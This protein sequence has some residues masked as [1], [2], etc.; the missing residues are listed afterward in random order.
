MPN[1][2][3]YNPTKKHSNINKKS[4]HKHNKQC[5]VK[6]NNYK[7]QN[8]TEKYNKSKYNK[9][10][11]NKTKY[12]K[13]KN[14]KTKK[15][16]IKLDDKDYLTKIG[17][18]TKLGKEDRH[19]ILLKAITN[20]GYS[21]VIKRLVE[22]RTLTKNTQPIKSKKYNNDIIGLQK[23]KKY[24]EQMMKGGNKNNKNL[25]KNNLTKIN[26]LIKN[27]LAIEKNKNKNKK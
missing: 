17:Y 5:Y 11:Y 16:N 26:K 15:V 12:N 13:T 18:S 25:S 8:T 19:K 21:S 24:M 1:T 7:K 6:G 2:C 27:I 14:N 20:Y 3:V 23:W 4:L 10:K 22:L 9:T